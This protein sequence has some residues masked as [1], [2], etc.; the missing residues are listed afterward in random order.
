MDGRTEVKA[1]KLWE[2]SDSFFSYYGDFHLKYLKGSGM[3]HGP[4]NKAAL[5]VIPPPADF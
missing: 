2:K 5:R 1:G 3:T 4:H